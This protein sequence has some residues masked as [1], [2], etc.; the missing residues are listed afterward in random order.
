MTVSKARGAKARADKLF[1]QLIRSRG[2]C[3]RCAASNNV[4]TAH[5]IGRRFSWVRTDERNA[6]ALCPTC[7][8]TVDNFADEKVA[9]VR[10]TIGEATYLSLRQ[11]SEQTGATFDWPAE[12]ERL[13]ARL[14]A[15]L[16][17]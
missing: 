12:V 14:E 9:L 8:Y 6:W 13:K 17:A 7:H 2:V 15:V 1:S 4:V 3:E 5:I 10:R 16:A 11:K